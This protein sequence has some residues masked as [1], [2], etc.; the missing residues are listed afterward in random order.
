MKAYVFDRKLKKIR[1]AEVPV[2]EPED[3]EVLIQIRAVSVNAADCRS[4]KMGMVPK[5][6]IYGSDISGE[7]VKTGSGVRNFKVH[8][9]VVADLSGC[10]MGGFAEF[11]SVPEN[12]PVRKPEGLTH[13]AAAAMPMASVTA[14]QALRKGNICKGQKV[15]I[16]GASGGVGSFAV[17]LA[18][19]FG[20]EVTGVC[21]GK[22]A[23]TVKS[24]GAGTV[25]DYEK[26][27]VFSMNEKYD[28][29][30]AVHGNNTLRA[31]AKILGAKGRLVV[32][33]G[34][35]S[36]IF[37]AML[38]GPLYSFGDKKLTVLAAKPVAEDLTSIL[39]LA[40]AGKITAHIERV[41][42][43]A[44]LPDVI[45]YVGNGHARGKIVISS[46]TL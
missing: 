36:Q 37:R 10:G 31:Y 13:Q 3:T 27:D 20:A 7:I 12:V 30:L 19:H 1:L 4:M 40:A 9:E 24:L 44:A 5:R 17:Q 41:S 16:Y 38:F 33:G 25:I 21:S 18:A 28:L 2:Q 23:E 42:G 34:E 26:Q 45:D 8:D 22:N 29:I 39:E 15:L 32:V 6:G 43:F 11:V 14:L 35:L 46:P